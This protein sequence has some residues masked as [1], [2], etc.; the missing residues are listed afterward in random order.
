M[1]VRNSHVC[2]TLA[3]QFP[4]KKLALALVLLVEAATH[5]RQPALLDE[6]TET[7]PAHIGK[8]LG[9]A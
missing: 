2:R 7:L 6:I 4:H 9:Q 1:S 8:A 5:A 3:S